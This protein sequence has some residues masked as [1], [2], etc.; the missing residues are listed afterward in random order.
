MDYKLLATDMDGT[1]LMDD[2]ALSTENIEALTRGKE[3]GIDL[4][5]CTGRPFPTVKPYLEQLGIS[6]WLVTNNGSVIRD[7]QENIIYEKFMEQDALEKIID[8]FESEKDLYYHVSDANHTYIKSRRQRM[9]TIQ[10]FVSIKN[11]SPIKA[12]VTA[13][14]MVFLSGTH[15]KV[16]FLSYVKNGGKV[17]SVFVYSKDNIQ[18]N[19]LKEKLSEIKSINVTS[20]G[21]D[22][23]EILDGNATKGH[24]LEYLSKK[25]DIQAEEMIAVG[26][27]YNDLSMIQYAGLGVAMRNGEQ[28][29]ID[30]ADWVTKTNQENGVAFLMEKVLAEEIKIIK[31]S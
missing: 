9:R 19:R 3:H 16:D 4:A 21:S 17:A 12:Y 13:A 8:I 11:M 2:K 15:K 25:L 14:K 24:A 22:N 28:A 26:D 23:I 30:E 20:S 29:I 6:C 27:N 31:I 1:L 7:K 18:L 10:K 5:I